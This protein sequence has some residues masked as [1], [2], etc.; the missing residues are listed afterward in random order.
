MLDMRVSVRRRGPVFIYWCRYVQIG[1]LVT[2][3]A[4]AADV[5]WLAGEMRRVVLL[6]KRQA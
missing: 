4:Q 1:L 3:K 2:G 5:W 6:K